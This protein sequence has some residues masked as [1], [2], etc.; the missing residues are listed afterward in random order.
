MLD[1]IPASAQWIPEGR[2]TRV[3]DIE[4]GRLTDFELTFG[5]LL[6]ACRFQGKR[7]ADRL[8]IMLRSSRNVPFAPIP[9]FY[10]DCTSDEMNGHILHI[11]DPT[12]FFDGELE[13]GVFYGTREHDAVTGLIRIAEKVASLLGL[14]RTRIVYWAPSG[15]AMGAAMAAIRS[16]AIGVL[17]NPFLDAIN[18]NRS[19]IARTIAAIFGAADA[20]ELP[21]KYP[22]RTRVPM[23]LTAAHALGICPK[24]LIVQNMRDIWFFKRQF[25]RFCRQH[26]VPL[27][28]GWDPTG[29]IMSIVYS[30]RD[31]HG[32]E[33]PEVRARILGEAL[34]QILV[35]MPV[36]AGGPKRVFEVSVNA[37]GR[38]VYSIPA[39]VSSVRL[40]SGAATYAHDP[41]TLGAAISR[42]SVDGEPVSMADPLL[43]QGFYD[44]ERDGARTWRWTNGDAKIPVLEFGK[45]KEL[46]IE[47]AALSSD[48]RSDP[49]QGAWAAPK[50]EPH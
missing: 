7:G 3:E 48:D 32:R 24:L 1:R 14:D 12:L 29:G 15:A 8:F 13:A 44:I 21:K 40:V 39:G 20:Q 17:V 28:G 23:A 43:H 27:K 16:G 19:Y 49:W 33:T 10:D 25:V 41:R 9:V 35:E 11:C 22:L 42:M 6:F 46:E 31:G 2:Y 38:N 18:M 5:D 37:I 50:P 36:S 45:G 4:V 30:D 26:S 47:V 34:P